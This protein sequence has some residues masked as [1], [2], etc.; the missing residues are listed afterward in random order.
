[1]ASQLIA[2]QIVGGREKQED[3]FAVLDLGGRDRSLVLVVADGMGGHPG[4]ADAAKL[5]TSAFCEGMRTA[6]GQ[7]PLR[8][9][10]ALHRANDAIAAA[11]K[12]DRKIS[13]AGCT[14]V[15]AAIENNAVS[16]ISVGDSS[17]YLFRRGLVRRLNLRHLATSAGPTD[18]GAKS[19]FKVL[20]SAVSGGK[21]AAVDI[22]QEPMKLMTDDCIIVASDGLDCIGERRLS[23][24][25]RRSMKRRPEEVVER[26]LGVVRSRPIA[27][28]DNTTVIFYRIGGEIQHRHRTRPGSGSSRPVWKFA[29]IAVLLA[30]LAFAIRYG[31]LH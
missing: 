29:L 20:R 12:T 5:A 3:D 11:A 27:A 6:V 8:L 4:A 19:R 28:Q 25:L 14:L 21:I 7:L 31:L 26:L 23:S 2:A 15:A 30:A 10:A 9:S 24:I 13:G 22:S 16:W 17:L 1:M 18:S